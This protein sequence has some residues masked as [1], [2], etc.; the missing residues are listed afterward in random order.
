MFFEID[1]DLIKKTENESRRRWFRDSE[2]ACDLFIWENAD[3][4]IERFQFWHEDALVE[5]KAGK[6]LR[7]GHVDQSSG[8]FTHYQTQL[9]RI[10]HHFDNELLSLV[11]DLMHQKNA[12]HED[13]F[14]QVKQILFEIAT[15]H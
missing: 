1:P 15:R 13:A 14:T 6:G 12:E 2:A 7:T 11:N 9:Y 8:S 5:W 4:K 3:Q 10:H